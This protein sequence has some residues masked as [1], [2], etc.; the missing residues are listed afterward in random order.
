MTTMEEMPGMFA[1]SKYRIHVDSNSQDIDGEA[2][3]DELG[4]SVSLSNVDL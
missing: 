3:G 1:F 2:S 4:S